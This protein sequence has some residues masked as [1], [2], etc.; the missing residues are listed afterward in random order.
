MHKL[1]SVHRTISTSWLAHKPI[2][3]NW[4]P[5]ARGIT[6]FSHSRSAITSALIGT[7]CCGWFFPLIFQ[8]SFVNAGQPQDNTFSIQ[9]KWLARCCHSHKA[10]PVECLISDVHLGVA[11]KRSIFSTIE[12][13]EFCGKEILPSLIFTQNPIILSSL[14]CSCFLSSKGHMIATHN[15]RGLI[16]WHGYNFPW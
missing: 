13:I 3:T 4:I 6:I 1:A 8:Y 11:R 12:V 15:R 7:P 14:P 16:C 5:T 10:G 9:F 2:L